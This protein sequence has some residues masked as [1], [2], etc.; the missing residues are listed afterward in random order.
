MRQLVGG[1]VLGVMVASVDRLITGQ[2]SFNSE[3]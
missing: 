3:Q 1:E 2:P